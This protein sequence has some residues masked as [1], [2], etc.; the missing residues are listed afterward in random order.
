IPLVLVAGFE[1]R[2]VLRLHAAAVGPGRNRDGLVH[3]DDLAHVLGDAGLVLLAVRTPRD[4]DGRHD[5]PGLP[6]F[7]FRGPGAFGADATER[8]VLL[9]VLAEVPDVPLLVLGVPVVGVFLHGA[10]VLLD[11]VDDGARHAEDHLRV[12]RDRDLVH[13]DLPPLALAEPVRRPRD[14]REVRMV[15]GRL[16]VRRVYRGRV[17][18]LLDLRFS[19]TDGDDRR[20]AERRRDGESIQTAHG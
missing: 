16:E 2:P 17:R 7:H 11:I 9:R 18:L 6:A 19:T 5:D 13:A 14:E 8:E 15:D 4:R 10:V 1:Q 20:D 3:G 12:V